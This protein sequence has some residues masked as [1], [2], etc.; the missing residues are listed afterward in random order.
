MIMFEKRKDLF[1]DIPDGPTAY[2]SKFLRVLIYTV[3]AAGEKEHW[4]F[5]I[6]RGINQNNTI[7]VGTTIEDGFKQDWEGFSSSRMAMIS[8]VGNTARIEKKIER[9]ILDGS[10]RESNTKPPEKKTGY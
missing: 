7:Y 6:Q 9:N 2:D 4:G 10:K 1:A 8:A 3:G 5:S